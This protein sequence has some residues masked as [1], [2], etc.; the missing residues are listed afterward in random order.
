MAG[1]VCTSIQLIAR[2]CSSS[3]AGTAER[4]RGPIGPQVTR[5]APK[6]TVIHAAP[7]SVSSGRRAIS[8]KAGLVTVLEVVVTTGARLADSHGSRP[9]G[10]LVTA[11]R[12][13]GQASNGLHQIF[14]LRLEVRQA[15]PDVFTSL[16]L[17]AGGLV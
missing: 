16:R 15:A 1:A 9:E 4:E 14:A 7:D 10:L 13:G 12:G 3:S 8:R 6:A 11:F 5:A 2:R 17:D